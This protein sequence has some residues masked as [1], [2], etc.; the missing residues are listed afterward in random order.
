MIV[1]SFFKNPLQFLVLEEPQV[2]ENMA[3]IP[4][5]LKE[6][7]FVDFIT[8]QEAEELNLIEIVETDSVN[9]LE[10]INNSDKEILIPFGVTVHGGKQDRTVWEPI[11]L[12]A[13]GK[14]KIFDQKTASIQ[15]Q[16]NVLNNQDGQ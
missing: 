9:Q 2:H 4:I 6:N 16:Q 5:V 15:Y 10:V 13:Q 8:I 12:P 1:E 3:V 11:L 14:G 7:K